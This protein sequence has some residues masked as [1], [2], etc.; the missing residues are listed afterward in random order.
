M[1]GCVLCRSAEQERPHLVQLK[2]R[3]TGARILT[4]D[5]GGIRGIIEL[6]L[7]QAINE[8]IGL[9]IYI[10]DMVDMIVG[11]STGTFISSQ[12]PWVPY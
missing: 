9:E 5:G 11:T 8:A 1:L 12:V 10:R 7:L 2:P 3:C 4:L 6:S